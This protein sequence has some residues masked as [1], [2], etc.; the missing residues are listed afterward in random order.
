M[1]VDLH[2]IGT[3]ISSGHSRN[4]F[5]NIVSFPSA[6]GFPAAGSYNS[7]LNDV[8]YPIA[9]GGASVTVL[10]VAYPSQ[11]CDVDVK[12]NGSGGTYT[13]WTTATDVQY[14]PYG[15]SIYTDP[16]LEPLGIEV[17][18]G[19]STYITGGTY[20]NSYY[21]D[22][23]GSS[24]NEG[25]NNSYYSDGTN[26]NL[27]GLNEPAYTQVPSG[28]SNYNNGTYTGY[29]WNG[30]GGY[31]YPVNGG[32]YYS[33]GTFI[34]FIPDSTYSGGVNI[35]GTTYYAQ[36]CGNDY[37]WNGSGAD[38]GA[39]PICKYY[40]NGTFIFNDGLGV[41]YYWDGTGGYYTV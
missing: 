15:S 4:G 41:D 8:T 22:G 25:T 19:S 9:N 16:T 3:G 13:D 38:G 12:N 31:N 20:Q 6:S 10:S 5:G 11:T 35:G 34:V 40:P 21:H 37:F 17:P 23:A 33:N 32:S 27:T 29:T 28:G 36:E 14:K 2:R 7:T 18:S 24:Y 39:V 1:G 26:T 30:S